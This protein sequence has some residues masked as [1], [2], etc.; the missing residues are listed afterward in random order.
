M[1]DPHTPTSHSP[2]SINPYEAPQSDISVASEEIHGHAKFFARYGRIGRLRYFL[3]AGSTTAVLFSF[4]VGWAI[5][6][7]LVSS[8]SREYVLSF[9]V[10][11]VLLVVLLCFFFTLSFVRRRVNDMGWTGWLLVLMFVPYVNF[12]FIVLLVCLPGQLEHNRYGAP[13]PENT[14]RVKI[15]SAVFGISLLAAILFAVV[16]GVQL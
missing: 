10:I 2:A 4:L 16:W 6:L 8:N 7:P 1:T 5:L 15:L 13:P 9:F 3:Y 11:S 14:S 12:L